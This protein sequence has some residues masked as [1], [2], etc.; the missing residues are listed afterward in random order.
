MPTRRAPAADRTARGAPDRAGDRPVNVVRGGFG[1]A[2]PGNLPEVRVVHHPFDHPYVHHACGT[3]AV[4]VDVWDVGALRGAAVDV[5]HLHFSFE[6]RSAA[7]LAHWAAARAA[8]ES[9]WST[10]ST[11]WTTR[12]S[13][14][15]RRST[16][17]SR[18]SSRPPTTS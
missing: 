14:T 2:A 15:R 3:P 6:T 10:P 11:T 5:V 7:E 18:C 9:R 1:R 4:R 13:S 16:V 8:M 12:T 17:W